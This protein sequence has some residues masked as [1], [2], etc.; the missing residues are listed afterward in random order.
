DVQMPGVNGLDVAASAD[1]ISNPLIVFV[2]AYEAHAV[3][4]F[5]IRATDYLLKPFSD[6]RLAESLDRVREELR[7]RAVGRLHRELRRFLSDSE[8]VSVSGAQELS[9]R[10]FNH[11]G[12]SRLAVR[13]GNRSLLVLVSDI[14]WVEA[15][16]TCSMLHVGDRRLVLRETL[17]SLES[18]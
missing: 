16:G 2:T 13:I 8:Q 1:P 15:D 18:R 10:V 7:L 17:D 12:A 3:D 11:S 14:D 4:A 5:A 9:S 6:E